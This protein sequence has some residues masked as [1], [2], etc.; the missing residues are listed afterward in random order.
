MWR[1]PTTARKGTDNLTIYVDGVAE[2][3]DHGDS[4]A[5]ASVARANIGTLDNGIDADLLGSK[6]RSPKFACGSEARADWQIADNS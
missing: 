6:G 3:S 5:I 4:P 1:S 2:G